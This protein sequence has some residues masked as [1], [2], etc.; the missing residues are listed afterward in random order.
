MGDAYCTEQGDAAAL[1][2]LYEHLRIVSACCS[3]VRMIPTGG[4]AVP[5]RLGRAAPPLFG[6]GGEEHSRMLT[7]AAHR[8]R[9]RLI[10]TCIAGVSV[11]ASPLGVVSSLFAVAAAGGG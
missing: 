3:L 8:R 9:N 5:A 10:R 11:A 4:E 7:V 1:D 2:P 6:F